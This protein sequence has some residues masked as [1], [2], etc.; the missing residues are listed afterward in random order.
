[1]L[2]CLPATRQPQGDF[3]L[4]WDP[5]RGTRGVPSTCEGTFKESYFP[6][7]S[8]SLCSEWEHWTTWPDSIAGE[9]K[10]GPQ[11][12]LLISSGGRN[13]P[14]PTFFISLQPTLGSYSERHRHGGH[15]LPSSLR[16]PGPCTVCLPEFN[17]QQWDLCSF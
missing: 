4:L 17:S 14:Y 12:S 16:S 15:S 1:M 2:A 9:G 11:Q 6:C 10:W 7:T 5:D 8:C 13:G 3:K